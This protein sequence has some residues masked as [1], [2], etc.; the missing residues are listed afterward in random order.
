MAQDDQ[1]CLK[2][3]KLLR[4]NFNG[5]I[6]KKG[7]KL[8]NQI[9]PLI[10][11]WEG[12]LP[13]LRYIFRPD[14]IEDL[15]Y[16]SAY[17]YRTVWFIDFVARTGYRDEPKVD[18]DGKPVLRRTTVVHRASWSNANIMARLFDIYNR[19]DL[20]YIDDQ[21]GRSHF[22][23]ACTSG[24]VEAVEKFIALG[25]DPNS[26]GGKS[27]DLPLYLAVT[28]NRKGVTESLLRNGANPNIANQNGS[29]PLHVICYYDYF[30]GYKRSCELAKMLFEVCNEI[31]RIVQVNARD[32]KGRTP[33]HLALFEGKREMV[34]LLLRNGADP[35]LTIENG[36]TPLH[37]ICRKAFDDE[38][39]KPFFE[40]NAEVNQ[41]V[42]VD[43]RDSEGRTPLQFAVSNLKPDVVDVLLDNGADL[44][45]FIFPNDLAE[46]LNPKNQENRQNF[47]LRLASS[48]MIMIE[49]L[50][51]RG[52]ELN[53][54]DALK[55]MKFFLEKVLE[56]S[57]VV[58]EFWYEEE[59]FANKAKNKMISPSLSLYDF[60]K[61]RPQEAARRLTY[62]DYFEIANSNKLKFPVKYREACQLHLC[63][64]MS[65]RFFLDWTME[66]FM[67]LINYRLPLLCSDM[68]LEELKKKDLYHI[69][70]A[71][72]RES[73]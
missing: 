13:N 2:Q 52:H 38:L 57:A 70:L 61:L 60:I 65:R 48:A 26:T 62:N 69:C 59:K 63:E 72:Q 20:N 42:P 15:L 29:T 47:K 32:D 56:T 19:F 58:D 17:H 44:S 18:E 16:R 43:A 64:I 7:Y 14:E 23:V 54:T 46:T 6:E 1:N 3:L 21:S 51:K 9:Y 11:N 10:S 4:K 8:L 34:E 71:D 41:L 67:K 25:Q 24:C 5:S 66:S 55:I 27:D 68:V 40:I 30:E 28:N 36:F 35:N 50:E 22:H 33:L 39:L 37:I 53:R 73:S 12:S 49:R 31:D 45:T